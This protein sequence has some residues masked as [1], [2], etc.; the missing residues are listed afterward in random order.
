MINKELHDLINEY[1][2]YRDEI[3]FTDVS[4]ECML[5]F[6]EFIQY[7]LQLEQNQILSK[8]QRLGLQ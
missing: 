1:I 7:K 6:N 2:E 4:E 8:I 5:S 3:N